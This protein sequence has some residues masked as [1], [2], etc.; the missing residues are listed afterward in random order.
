MMGYHTTLKHECTKNEQNNIKNN[1]NNRTKVS[2]SC[3]CA[4]N[5]LESV[6]HSS[7]GLTSRFWSEVA[8]MELD[9]RSLEVHGPHFETHYYVGGTLITD[10]M[11]DTDQYRN[12]FVRRPL[13]GHGPRFG[14][15]S[16]RHRL[17]PTVSCG[18]VR[19]LGQSFG[20]FHRWN[21]QNSAN[22]S[23]NLRK[24]SI[25][26]KINRKRLPDVTASFMLTFP[27]LNG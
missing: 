16:I 19:W 4:F 24:M 26:V 9:P 25:P 22:R 27:Q 5:S 12:L 10:E 20:I 8:W 18:S 7:P 23:L 2:L 15:P 6:C 3:N 17:S 11:Y 21:V 13:E 14:K 1:T